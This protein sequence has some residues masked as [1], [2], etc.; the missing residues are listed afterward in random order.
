VRDVEREAAA[1]EGGGGKWFRTI[2]VQ[3]VHGRSELLAVH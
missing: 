1:V 3:Q 2:G